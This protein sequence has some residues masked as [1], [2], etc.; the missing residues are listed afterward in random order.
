MPLN[1]TLHQ[2]GISLH[3]GSGRDKVPS[4]NRTSGR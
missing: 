2:Q 4:D 1:E 3:R